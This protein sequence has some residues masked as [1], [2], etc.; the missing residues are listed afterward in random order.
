[1]PHI[2]QK[3]FTYAFIYVINLHLVEIHMLLYFV[4]K[5]TYLTILKFIMKTFDLHTVHLM[6]ISAHL[7]TI[8]HV[9]LSPF[10]PYSNQIGNPA[11]AYYIIKCIESI[12]TM[13]SER[14]C[15][16]HWH[17]NLKLRKVSKQ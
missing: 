5:I 6:V 16:K 13:N 1:M 15:T 11:L 12:D 7:C 3:Y 2:L 8:T 4:K 10:A 9:R 17:G 14:K